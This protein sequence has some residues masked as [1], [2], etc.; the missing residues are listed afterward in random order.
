MAAGASKFPVLHVDLDGRP[1]AAGLIWRP[2]TS[3]RAGKKEMTTLSRQSGFDR[4]IL[5]QHKSNAQAGFVPAGKP[6]PKKVQSLAAALAPVLGESWI[7]AF[8]VSEDRYVMA[9]AHGGAI[10]PGSDVVGPRELVLSIFNEMSALVRAAG[11]DWARIIAPADFAAGGEEITAGELLAQ[12]PKGEFRIRALSFKLSKVQLAGALVLTGAAIGGGYVVKQHMA[13]RAEAARLE[14]VKQAQQEQAHQKLV[15]EQRSL[16]VG[17]WSSM[18]S[19]SEMM[20]TCSEGW[21]QIELTVAGWLFDNG[22][23][24]ANKLTAVYRRIGSATV[25]QFVETVRPRFGPP[26]IQKN[27]EIGAVVYRAQMPVAAEPV[28]PPIADQMENFVSH[29]QA[30]AIEIQLE[31]RKPGGIPPAPG[32]DADAH[33]APW[34]SHAFTLTTEYPPESA[35]K[36]LAIPGIRINTIEVVFSHE[37]SSLK[38]TVKGQLYG[39]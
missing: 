14:L 6:L 1:Y 22:R 28:L 35:F 2:V 25:K 29:F 9:A 20:A 8:R 30:A 21:T 10:M 34:Y 5:R 36:G 38:W 33:V 19:A 17:P 39:K 11:E 37:T 32:S 12:N 13:A 15:E 16:A 4:A 7:A 24:E 3:G 31:D 23:C 26:I 27:G 18:P